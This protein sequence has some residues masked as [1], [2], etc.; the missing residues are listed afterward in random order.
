M[1]PAH[2]AVRLGL[3]AAT[4]NPELSFGK[5]LLDA[6]G[7]ALSLLPPLMVIAIL[8]AGVG[9]LDGFEAISTAVLA[10]V[11]MRWALV[12][13]SF[14]VVVLSWALGMAFWSGALPVL[15]ADAELQRRP[16]SGH[17]WPLA[18]RGF[19]RVAS[20]GAVAYGFLLLFAAALIACGV[21]GGVAIIA[22]ATPVRFAMI[23]LLVSV[24]VV[25]G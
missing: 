10:L 6:L 14:T 4:R 2:H 1:L 23:A 25:F 19:G 11:R 5:A 17:F 20:A 7:T 21:V 16:P 9:R 18:L 3:R 15:A 24:A 8:A 22:R 13:A 12:G